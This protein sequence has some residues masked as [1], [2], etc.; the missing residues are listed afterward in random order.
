MNI[1]DIINAYAFYDD[2]DY[3]NNDDNDDNNKDSYTNML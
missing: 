2:N 1:H 3:N